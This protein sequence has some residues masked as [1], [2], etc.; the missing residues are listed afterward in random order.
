M[1]NFRLFSCTF[2]RMAAK[3][4]NYISQ[5]WMM[6]VMPMAIIS[7]LC[8]FT[9]P[10]SVCHVEILWK[11]WERVKSVLKCWAYWESCKAYS[12]NLYGT[13][14]ERLNEVQS[15]FKRN[16]FIQEV[17]S[18]ACAHICSCSFAQ[19]ILNAEITNKYSNFGAVLVLK[20]VDSK[21]LRQ[22]W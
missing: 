15:L 19:L 1:R 8:H 9:A 10:V 22:Y 2:T 11:R 6:V 18:C 12:I 14:N 3:F 20:V 21:R 13:L 7:C 4:F 16:V 17:N 5:I